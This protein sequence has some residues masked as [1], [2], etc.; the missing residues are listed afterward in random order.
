MLQFIAASSGWASSIKPL[1]VYMMADDYLVQKTEQVK[2]SDQNGMQAYKEV[3][4]QL[5]KSK[6]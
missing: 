3:Q 5:Q 2:T 6:P 4:T 1:H